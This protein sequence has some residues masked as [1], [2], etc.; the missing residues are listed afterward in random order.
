MTMKTVLTGALAL[1]GCAALAAVTLENRNFRLTLGDDAQAKSLVVKATGEE[2]LVAAERLPFCA[3]TQPRPFN[4]ELKLAYPNKRTVFPANR[5]RRAG[6]SLVFGFEL[7]PYEAEVAVEVADGFMAFT[8]SRFI[9]D[10][11]AQFEGLKMDL[12]PVSEF[13]VIQLAVKERANHG[14]WLNA[15]HDDRAA[16]AVVGTSPWPRVDSEARASCRVMHVD[17]LAEV[18]REG[19]GGAIVAAAD[20]EGLLD[21]LDALEERFD[22]PRGV[23]SRRSGILNRSIGWTMDLT[24][25]NVDAHIALC[26]KFGFRKLLVYY[27]AFS[28]FMKGYE[29]LGDYA[30]NRSYP[31]GLADLKAVVDRL[32][33]AG[34]MPGFHTL[35][36]HVGSMSSYVTP[37][38]D[39]RLN[40]KRRFTLA[41]PY[42]GDDPSVIEVFENP[43]A[44]PTYMKTRVLKFGGELFL[45]EGYTAEP[46][47]QFTGV[48]R[49][50]W[51]TA[52][53]THP[54]G[55]I[56]GVLDVSEYGAISCYI[57]QKTDLQDEIAEKI[58]KIYDL[59]FEFCYFDGSEGVNEPYEIY[60]PLSQYR[61]CRKFKKMPLFTEG[62]AKAHFSWHL[63]A[64][65]NAFD[66]FPPEIFKPMIAKHPLAEAPIMRRDFT[67]LDFGWWA[68]MPPGA[69]NKFVKGPSVGIQPDMIEYGT[70]KAAAWDCPATVM[71]RFPETPG[72]ARLDDLAET[73]RRWEEVRERGLMTDG[74]RAKLRDP[75]REFHLYRTAE[76]AYELVEW[77]QVRVGGQE[78]APGLR[79]FLFERNGRR[80]VAYWH[81]SGEA[82]YA[83][84]DGKGT[85]VRAGRLRY[86]ETDAA[87]DAVEKAFAG[88]RPVPDDGSESAR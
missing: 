75:A 63:Q 70:S 25:Q 43:A 46:P 12:P 42:P 68:L 8:L 39:P 48:R 30:F 81:T 34:I 50:H 36:T 5:V 26:R 41:K 53:Q 80:V 28:G 57:D 77:E 17:A 88:A 49:G 29:T 61:V 67:G 83:L 7:I 54:C 19:V 14:L 85:L 59:G 31:N 24:P 32:R 27:P 33:D 1:L 21:A 87:R 18:R 15:M 84:D 11:E 73:V 71:L 82:R 52:P 35:Q 62:A 72:L 45:Y 22:L 16:L 9:V 10:R 66:V 69:R 44:S 40:L 56:G 37:V 20:G 55:E 51:K 78:H 74:W 6:D 2:T 79:A 86:H 60:V 4:N 47:Y 38:A 23:K 76:G 64:G 65:A 58:A 13:R 3:V